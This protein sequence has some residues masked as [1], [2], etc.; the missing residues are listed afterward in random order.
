MLEERMAAKR[1]AIAALRAKTGTVSSSRELQQMASSPSTPVG[2]KGAVRPASPDE[3]SKQSLAEHRLAAKRE[4]LQQL[5]AARSNLKRGPE[6]RSKVRLGM[7]RIASF[8]LVWYRGWGVDVCTDLELHTYGQQCPPR[9]IF[10]RNSL[11]HVLF[12]WR[13]DPADRSLVNN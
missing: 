5:R 2:T 9:S 1:A 6:E 3:S 11:V 13:T 7:G 10:N 8:L 4:R 12:V